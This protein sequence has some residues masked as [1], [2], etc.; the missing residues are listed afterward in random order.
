[1][2]EMVINCLAAIGAIAWITWLVKRLKAASS[3]SQ[4]VPQSA[5]DIAQPAQ[6]PAPANDDVA[7]I[8]AAVYAMIGSGRIVHIEN[9]SSGQHWTAEGRW[10]HQNSHRTR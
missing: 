1:M 10:L 5:V 6:V 4:A 7:V 9:T 2:Y 3:Q 8:A